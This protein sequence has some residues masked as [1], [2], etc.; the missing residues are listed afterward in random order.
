MKKGLVTQDYSLKDTLRYV[1]ATG[2]PFAAGAKPASVAIADVNDDG[3]L[4]LVSANYGDNS[5]S[6]LL[7]TGTGGFD[8]AN[9]FTVGA[10]PRSVAIADINHD[11]KLD[12]V[13]A[14]YY[15]NDLSVLLGY[16]NGR[17]I[18]VANFL[19]GAEPIS[20]AI[21]DVNN[22][23]KLDL[24][25]ANSLT[26]DFSIL[27][28][29]GTGKFNLEAN[30]MTGISPASVAIAD[31]NDDGKL[32][33]VSANFL[34]NDLSV[35]LGTGTGN[36]SAAINYPVGF[37]P[38]SVAIADVND[39]G[40]LDLVSANSG[41]GLSVLLG[42]GSGSFDTANNFAVDIPSSVAIADVNND[43]K[44]DLV[45]A[46]FGNDFSVLLGKGNGTFG[47]ATNFRAGL[48]PCS[49]ALGDVNNDGKLDM[50]SANWNSNNLSVLLNESVFTNSN[51]IEEGHS[52]VTSNVKTP[53]NSMTIVDENDPGNATTESDDKYSAT[54]TFLASG[55][56]A[57][58]IKLAN[59][60][61]I[62][63]EKTTE[64]EQL[65]AKNIAAY[66][67][68][69]PV[70]SNLALGFT[71]G[72]L[73]SDAFAAGKRWWNGKKE[74]LDTVRISE[75]EQ[76]QT[77][78]AFELLKGQIEKLLVRGDLEKWHRYSL[79][80]LMDEINEANI[81]QLTLGQ[82]EEWQT[83][84]VGIESGYKEA[85]KETTKTGSRDS[86][87]QGSFFKPQQQH[88]IPEQQAALAQPKVQ[89]RIVA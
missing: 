34:G 51:L 78:A 29:T 47:S 27:L 87:G 41:G 46:N 11:G 62:G 40:K 25:S 10:G 53:V 66:Q 88:I 79:E 67:E 17:F 52:N 49:V 84:L 13:S 65:I 1:N 30:V 56:S 71:L 63:N 3:K 7:G 73:A 37:E 5:L 19:T 22:D 8:T 35:L 83:E 43:G 6:V 77:L 54:N 31:V 69:V 42:T 58:S 85:V 74:A 23:G 21:A 55:F 68:T 81:K 70:A 2:S 9:N 64:Q 72:K 18:L 86:K 39:D 57:H 26:H 33:L 14:N 38:K 48:T 20:V 24:V 59:L 45:S 16:G 61:A 89:Q 82:V 12:L 44:L 15:S 76:K 80:D 50:V 4:D 28:G 60:P 36:F 75:Q 32:D